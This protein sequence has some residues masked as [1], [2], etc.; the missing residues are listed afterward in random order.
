MI[1]AEGLEPGGQVDQEWGSGSDAAARGD[2]RYFV[3]P[4]QAIDAVALNPND[5]FLS[6]PTVREAISLAID[7]TA[8]AEIFAGMVTTSLLSPAVPGSDLIDEVSPEQNIDRA[9]EL[10]DGR[11]GSVTVAACE[12]PGCEAWAE[13]IAQQLD[14]IGITV[15]IRLVEDPIGEA[16][17]PES[18]IGIV[19]AFGDCGCMIPGRH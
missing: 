1:W 13:A 16:N 8:Q 7:R 15:E 11:T 5:P 12:F 17:D 14:P 2:Q 9:L 3:S 18:G 6:D 10:M 4:M 19:N